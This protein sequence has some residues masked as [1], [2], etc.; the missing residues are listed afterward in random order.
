MYIEQKILK[1]IIIK[2]NN[3]TTKYVIHNIAEFSFSIS[4]YLEFTLSDDFL[5]LGKHI[6]AIGRKLGPSLYCR[7]CGVWLEKC[8]SFTNPEYKFCCNCEKHIVGENK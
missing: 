2:I 7:N 6:T 5:K 4:H 3:T 1:N 8:Y